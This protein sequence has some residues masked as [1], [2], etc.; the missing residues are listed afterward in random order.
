MQD[1][2]KT[3]EELIKKH[4]EQGDN[5]LDLITQGDI[6]RCALT[7]YIKKILPEDTTV[8][9]ENLLFKWMLDGKNE[10]GRR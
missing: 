6:C 9:A 3:I 8:S 4:T 2:L 7:E 5:V 10:K 1:E